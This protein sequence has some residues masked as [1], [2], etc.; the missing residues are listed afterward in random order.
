MG[1][2]GPGA[3]VLIIIELPERAVQISFAKGECKMAM[4]KSLAT[5]CLVLFFLWFGL[6][7]FV[8]SLMASPV[9]YVGGILAL[10]VA[11]FTFLGK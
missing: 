5:W 2:N 1:R 8:P 3:L 9:T 4:P 11:V 6:G 10:G 7:A